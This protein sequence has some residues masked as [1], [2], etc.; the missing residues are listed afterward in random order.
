MY[1]ILVIED[2]DIIRKSIVLSIDYSKLG[3]TIVAEAN[4]GK[5]GKELII[6]HNPQIII[7]D[8]NMPI[9]DGIT[10]LED[11]MEFDYV[12]IIISGYDSFEYAKKT[13]KY[14]ATDY[15]LKPIDMNEL[16]DSIKNAINIFEMRISYN[17]SKKPTLIKKMDAVPSDL[18]AQIMDYI[19][20]NYS[21][22]ISLK[23]LCNK[24]CYSESLLNQKFKNDFGYTFNEYLNRYRITKSI[25]LLNTHRYT[26][27]EISS[28]TGFM[29][30]RYF[31]KVFKKY[32][33]V[34]PSQYNI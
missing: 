10:L 16:K 30:P 13:M 25:E 23:D 24:L 1:K 8:I 21:A 19:V 22:K 9:V 15:L 26:I 14:G 29:D 18:S 4:N 34:L 3:C 27:Y 12:P 32:L 2:E 20:K 17:N 11:T 28:L 33:G 6:K 5:V 31:S 7:L